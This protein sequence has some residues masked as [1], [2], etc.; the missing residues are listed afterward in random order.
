MVSRLFDPRPIAEWSIGRA[1]I[2]QPTAN[3]I[4]IMERIETEALRR[5]EQGDFGQATL[6]RSRAGD[7]WRCVRNN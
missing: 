6:V 3:A 4:E 2:F 7:F 5:S 1:S